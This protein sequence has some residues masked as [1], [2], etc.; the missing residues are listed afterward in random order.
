VEQPDDQHDVAV[1]SFA[2]ELGVLKRMRRAG[3]WHVG[4]RDPESVAEHSLRVAQLASLIA[5]IEGADP[6]RAT[7]LAVWHDS[8]E[9]RTGDIPHTAKPYLGKPSPDAITADQTAHLPDAA[10]K[11]VQEAVTEYEAQETAEARCARDADKLECM[12][13][14]IEYRDAGCASVQGWIDSSHDALCTH[15]ARRIANAAL[16]TSPLDWRR[17]G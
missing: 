15:A 1:A 3:W 6:A 2:F 12:I 13:Q 14:A 9:T 4:V 11:T 7:F 17:R 5:A 10:R 8:Q 16:H